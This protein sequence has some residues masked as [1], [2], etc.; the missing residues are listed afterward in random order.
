MM[1]RAA[2]LI[3]FARKEHG[4]AAVEFGIIALVFTT[5]LMASI[6]FARLGWELNQA[7][8]AARIGARVAVVNPMVADWMAGDNFNSAAGVAGNGSPVPIADVPV[9]TCV[10]TSAT[11]A[12][13]VASDGNASHGAANNAAFATIFSKMRAFDGEIQPANVS[14]E[15]RH[16]GLGIVGDPYGHA[17][18]PLVTV[19]LRNLPFRLGSLAPFGGGSFT[20]P[21]MTSSY[22]GEDLG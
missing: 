16:V 8:T 11:S 3:A 7:K 18:E 2:S 10:G 5:M 9:I 13:C 1:S 12:T 20:L 19:T 6:D 17:V 4:S 22:T 21:S 14:I 15:Y